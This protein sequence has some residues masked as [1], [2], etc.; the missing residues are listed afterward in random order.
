LWCTH[1]ADFPARLPSR[2]AGRRW[3]LWQRV[4]FWDGV[5]TKLDQLKLFPRERAKIEQSIVSY[6]PEHPAL[7]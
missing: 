3:T 1:L 4:D 7:T 5:Q 6:V 2:K